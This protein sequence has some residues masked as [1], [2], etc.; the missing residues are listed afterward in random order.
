MIEA[1]LVEP[2][3]VVSSQLLFMIRAEVALREFRRWMG[4]RRLQDADHAMHCLL[5]E[6]FGEQAPRPFRLIMPRDQ[7][8]GVLYGYTRVEDNDL[9]GAAVAFADPAQVRILPPDRIASKPMPVEW[10]P[11]RQ[12]GF[13]V[14]IR[15]TARR[16]RNADCRPGKECD[17]FALQASRYARG[18]M[19]HSREAVYA[20]WLTGQFDRRGGAQLHRG[21]TKLVSFRRTRAVRKRHA[22]YSE[23]PDAVMRGVLTITDPPAFSNLLA[24]GIGRHRAYGYGMLLLRPA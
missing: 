3:N 22:R 24:N 11:G 19:P 16:S 18:E 1:A 9:R 23:G 10:R 6:S 2:G 17:A 5:T 7:A 20:D 14:R 8:R 13:E 21:R 12:L 4:M 15:P